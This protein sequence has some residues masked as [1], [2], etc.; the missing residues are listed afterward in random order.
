M[1][2]VPRVMLH[3]PDVGIRWNLIR[4]YTSR[5]LLIGSIILIVLSILLIV[6][7]MVF[8]IRDHMMPDNWGTYEG[9]HGPWRHYHPGRELIGLS[10]NL[11]PCVNLVM[12]VRYLLKPSANTRWLLLCSVLL[13]ILVINFFFWLID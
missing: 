4:S 13:Y 11:L 7:A 9:N 1:T 12:F 3:T 8:G 10:L 6:L 2:D 5:L